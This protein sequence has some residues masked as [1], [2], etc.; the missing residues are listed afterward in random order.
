MRIFL[1]IVLSL[2]EFAVLI[3][4]LLYVVELALPFLISIDPALSLLILVALSVAF[5]I[6]A[7]ASMVIT[8][9]KILVEAKGGE[10]SD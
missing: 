3:V 2:I 7:L 8:Y 6:M 1:T 5:G 9:Q 10:A 4:I